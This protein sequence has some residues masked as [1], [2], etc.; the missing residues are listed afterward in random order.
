MANAKP[1]TTWDSEGRVPA[2]AYTTVAWGDNISEA[3]ALTHLVSLMISG[4]LWKKIYMT[5]TAVNCSW[6]VHSLTIL[7]CCWILR[8]DSFIK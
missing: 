7:A 2:H 4:E 1:G 3:K 6:I 5:F 8:K